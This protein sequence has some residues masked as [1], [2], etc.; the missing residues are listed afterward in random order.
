[1]S[2]RNDFSIKICYKMVQ[3]CTF[4][5]EKILVL[6]FEKTLKIESITKIILWQD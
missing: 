2:L 3:K 4:F 1:M 6:I 5:Y